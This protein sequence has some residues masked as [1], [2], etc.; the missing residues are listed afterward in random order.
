[1]GGLT[2]FHLTVNLDGYVF[3]NIFVFFATVWSGLV[4]FGN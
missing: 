4:K 1:M 3:Q 2:V